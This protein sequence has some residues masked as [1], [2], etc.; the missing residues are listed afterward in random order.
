MTI[1][2]KKLVINE[3]K[4][5]LIVYGNSAADEKEKRMDKYR[6]LGGQ[7]R[8]RKDIDDKVILIGQEVGN[9]LRICGVNSIFDFATE[10]AIGGIGQSVSRIC[11]DR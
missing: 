2:C 7:Q 6:M 8:A 1:Y 5:K 10:I 9:K 4:D 3:L 11:V